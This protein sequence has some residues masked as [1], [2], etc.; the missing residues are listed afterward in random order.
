MR[1]LTKIQWLS[2]V[3]CVK[4]T[5]GALHY[6]YA[7]ALQVETG[8]NDLRTRGS[9]SGCRPDSTVEA[10]TAEE[11]EMS[12]RRGNEGGEPHVVVLLE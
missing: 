5:F 11:A 6:A 8:T 4:D 1:G 2:V 7:Y 3:I 12:N 9:T 10:A